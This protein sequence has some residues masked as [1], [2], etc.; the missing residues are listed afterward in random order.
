MKG[1]WICVLASVVAGAITWAGTEAYGDW[2]DGR[3]KVVSYLV[4]ND[5]IRVGSD[6]GN[7]VKTLPEGSKIAS[8]EI[9][10]VG[11]EEL[12][13]PK[14]RIASAISPGSDYILGFGIRKGVSESTE[15]PAIKSDG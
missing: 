12:A 8:V 14:F 7:T 11:R 6:L 15:D 9:K 1:F 13:S 4:N 3:A 5:E 10:N 2:R